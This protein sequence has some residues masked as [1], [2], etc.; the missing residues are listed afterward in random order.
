[1][2]KNYFKTALKIFERNKGFTVINILGLSIGISAA[3]VIFLIVQHDYSFDKFEKAGNRIYRVVENYTLKVSGKS[4]GSAATPDPLGKAVNDEV[5]GLEVVAALRPGNDAKISVPV[6]NTDKRTVFNNQKHI[7]FTEANY[8]KLV[9]Y[10]W[11]AGN[12][13]TA[14]QQPYQVVLTAS[15][16]RLYFPKLNAAQV[17]GQELYFDDTVRTIVTG[18]VEDIKQNTVFN[19][20]T[21]VSRITLETTSLKPGFWD[22]WDHAQSSMVFVKLAPGI[23]TANIKTQIDKLFA[24]YNK[25]AYEDP[26][27]RTFELQSLSGIHFKGYFDSNSPGLADKTILRGLMAVA[28]FLLVLACI[29]FINLTTAQASGRSKEIGIRKTM[30]SSKKQLIAQFMG[31]TFLLTLIATIISAVTTPVLLKAF[32]TYIPEGV[33]FTITS[34]PVV[35]VFLLLLVIVVSTLAGFYPAIMLS[36]YKPVLALKNQ[37]YINTSQSRNAWLRK[38]LTISQFVIAQVFIIATLL[39]SK[40]INYSLNKNI[41]IKKDAIIY[42]GNYTD[43][44]PAKKKVLVD[45]L[46]AIPG[47]AMVSLSMDPPASNSTWIDAMKYEDSKKQIQTDVQV[48]IGDSNYIRLYQIKLLAG[49]NLVNNDTMGNLLINETYLHALGF[50]NPQDIIGQN[51]DVYGKKRVAGVVQ[52]FHQKSLRETISPLLIT[53]GIMNEYTFNVALQPQ[54]ANGNAWQKTIDRVRQA[55]KE[56]YPEKDFDYAFLDDAIAAYYT[57]EQNVSALLLWS[58]G[59]TIFISCLG[60]LGLVIHITNLRKKEIG[61]RK[62]VGAT[63][64]QIVSLLSKD[65]LSLIV[66]AFIIAVPIAWYAANAWLQNFAYRTTLSWWTFF[67]GGLLMFLI[68]L[69]ILCIRTIKAAIANPVK[70][71]RTE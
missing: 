34:Q 37:A 22:R 29:N 7:V 42:F 9:G 32:A 16:A 28:A 21:F 58:T 14:L 68:A 6:E 10:S 51:I 66:I 70:S 35:F 48:K 19:Y 33:K 25:P 5:T 20:T 43:A 36:S 53:G 50:T 69:I 11:L 18:V 3:L 17:I 44:S 67:A 47:V 62:V 41:G 24:K 45:K 40:Q 59:L 54:N 63:V 55:W 8:F 65:F 15:N 49:S 23:K 12:P 30:G 4:H 1:M 27:I 64:G 56:I 57:A 2:F 38:G 46:K 71:L 31:E 39:V 61:I 52:D 13:V 60:L 26:E